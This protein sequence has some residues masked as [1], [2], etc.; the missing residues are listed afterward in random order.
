MTGSKGNVVT[1]ISA[2]IALYWIKPKHKDFY[3]A[4]IIALCCPCSFVDVQPKTTRSG[5]PEVFKWSSVI[6]RPNLD[7]VVELSSHRSCPRPKAVPRS[8]SPSTAVEDIPAKGFDGK[9]PELRAVRTRQTTVTV[10]CNLWQGRYAAVIHLFTD[11]RGKGRRG[12]SNYYCLMRLNTRT[13]PS[14]RWKE[15]GIDNNG[16]GRGEGGMGVALSSGK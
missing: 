15:G 10:I 5:G 1:F 14:E 4:A 2:D 9:Y 3:G 13:I 6:L 12:S 16:G 8:K 7:D 11:K